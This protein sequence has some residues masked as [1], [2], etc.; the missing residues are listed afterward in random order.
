MATIKGILDLSELDKSQL[1]KDL[2]LQAA[3]VREGKLLGTAV[4][5]V[6]ENRPGRLPFEVEFDPPFLPGAILP[7]PVIVL[8][9]PHVVEEA[10]LE[11]NTIRHEVELK[12]EGEEDEDQK[13][14][15]GKKGKSKQAEVP[16]V[17][18]VDLGRI[19]VDPYIYL[20]WLRI[21]RTYTIRGRVVCRDW[22]YDSIE[23]QWVWCD[24]PVPGAT[25]EAYDVDRWLWLSRRD[26][27][28]STTTKIDGTFEMT[29]TWC[30]TFRFPRLQPPWQVDPDLLKR[31]RDLLER[32]RLPMPPFPP[33]PRPDPILLQEWATELMEARGD[34]PQPVQTFSSNIASTKLDQLLPASPEL[35]A[36][37]VWP[38]LS[39]RDCRPDIVFRVTQPCSGE[40]NVIF[41][42]TNDQARWDIDTEIDVTLVANDKA[43]CIP[44]CRDPEC[45]ECIDISKV[46]CTPFPLIGHDS[47]APNL[48]GYGH[49]ASEGDNP[50]Y[51]NMRFY[52]NVGWDVDYLKVQYSFNGGGWTDLAVPYFGGYSRA[53]WDGFDFIPVSFTPAPKSGQMVIMT[54]RHYEDLNPGVPRFGGYVHWNDF[55]SLFNFNSTP[56]GIDPPPGGT[57]PLADGLY[58]F[59][60]VGYSADSSDNLDLSSERVLPFCGQTKTATVYVRLDNQ[61]KIHP[62]STPTHPWGVGTI[63]K[64]TQEPDAYFREIWKNEGT[65]EAKKIEACDIV[66]LKATD[67]LTIHFT[68]AVP[69]PPAA[70]KDYHL[71]GY[72]MNV[73][74]GYSGIFPVGTGA[75]GVF[76]GD[77]TPHVGP[78]YNKALT[79][80]ATRPHWQGGDYK[81]TLSG[82]DFPACCAYLVTL[83]AWK[84]TTNGCTNVKW[85]HFNRSSV[86]FTVLRPEQCP[87][88]CDEDEEEQARLLDRAP[89][90]RA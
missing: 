80:G 65:S 3:V 38:W 66:R 44:V 25:V 79:Q 23:Q 34:L 33:E 12:L 84:R 10:F 27:V 36:L 51:A 47:V 77:P 61:A 37:R 82:E 83:H 73:Q 18:E 21:C 63:H 2:R 45:P 62:A 26:L 69:S 6:K 7:C 59:R 67:K 54:R 24:N 70:V 15:K 29:F 14:D 41:T 35:K 52:G 19:V 22:R 60:F 39:W 56:D 49:V 40:V 42:E 32:Y 50:F 74:Y 30:C 17:A 58:K 31:I 43:C 75:H 53:Y 64:E 5:D 46:G 4:L 88:V 72:S 48:R 28:T 9:G 68:A 89:L 87:D 85:T 90:A 71:G 16:Y 20:G 86:S 81:V 11:I 76:S 78:S 1:D 13:S 57:P 8:I 55:T